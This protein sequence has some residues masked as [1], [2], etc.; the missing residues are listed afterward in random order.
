MADRI[1][2]FD[3]LIPAGTAI[4]SPQSTSLTFNPGIVRHITIVV[5]PGPSG[6]VGFR[7]RHSGEPIIPHNRANWIIA[8]N[9]KIDWPLSGFPTG[10]AWSVQAYNIDGFDHTLYFRLQVDE[11]ARSNAAY[12]SIVPI[13]PGASAEDDY[14]PLALL[15]F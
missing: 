8:D 10:A 4:A 12:A 5:P 2:T 3:V 14:D 15:D 11:T 1:E 7:I 13:A 9:D 6:L